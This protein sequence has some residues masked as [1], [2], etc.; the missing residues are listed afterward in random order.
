MSLYVMSSRPREGL[1]ILF[2]NVSL[3]SS[4]IDILKI[5]PNFDSNL[6]NYIGFGTLKGKEKQILQV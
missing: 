4:Y 2:N 3:D 5:F 6:C 1:Y